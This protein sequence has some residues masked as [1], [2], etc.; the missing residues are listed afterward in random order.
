MMQPDCV[1][2]CLKHRLEWSNSPPEKNKAVVYNRLKD[3]RVMFSN[4]K[5]NLW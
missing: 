4:K 2:V 5:V 1:D 3:F